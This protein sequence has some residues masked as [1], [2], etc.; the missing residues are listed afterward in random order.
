MTVRDWKCYRHTYV[1]P[2]F[3]CANNKGNKFFHRHNGILLSKMVRDNLCYTLTCPTILLFSSYSKAFPAVGV[4]VAFHSTPAVII[5]TCPI[6]NCVNIMAFLRWMQVEDHPVDCYYCWCSYGGPKLSNAINTQDTD[7]ATRLSTITI[8]HPSE[9]GW[10][11][12]IPVW[13]TFDPRYV[14]VVKWYETSIPVQKGLSVLHVLWQG[15]ICHLAS[16][17]GVVLWNPFFFLC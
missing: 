9:T 16:L 7:L 1:S 10:P 8:I 14:D 15:F 4:V 5:H 13:C 3:Q 11:H 6:S 12:L 2:R 17:S